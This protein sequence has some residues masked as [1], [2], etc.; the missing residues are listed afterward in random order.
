MG[1]TTGVFWNQCEGVMVESFT[2]GFRAHAGRCPVVHHHH[3]C[4]CER[5]EAVYTNIH[6]V[7]I[8]AVGSVLLVRP[9]RLSRRKRRIRREANIPRGEVETQAEAV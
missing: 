6:E 9:M 3:V 2:E 7:G 4:R 8:C 5:I 1:T